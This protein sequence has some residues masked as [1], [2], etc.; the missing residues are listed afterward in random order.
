LLNHSLSR[1]PELGISTEQQGTQLQLNWVLLYPWQKEVEAEESHA[2]P[3]W[4]FSQYLAKLSGVK[5]QQE[6]TAEKL[7]IRLYLTQAAEEL[8]ASC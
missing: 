7:Q 4:V 6:S 1:T 5:L 3:F 8:T 2:E